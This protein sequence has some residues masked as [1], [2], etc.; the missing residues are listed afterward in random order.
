[1]AYESPG[2]C[3]ICGDELQI[4]RLSCPQCRTAIEGLFDQC[5]FCRL[6]TEQR[7][8]AEVFIKCRGNIRELERELG[9]SYPTVRGRLEQLLAAMGFSGAEV[10]PSADELEP[11]SKATATATAVLERLSEGAI[12]VDAALA[13]LGAPGAPGRHDPKRRNPNRD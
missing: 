3:P 5:R 13:A 2:K 4:A 10:Q 11:E 1:M 7:R 8:F 6:G 12:S 9:I